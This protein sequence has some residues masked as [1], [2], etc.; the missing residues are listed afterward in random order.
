MNRIL[1]AIWNFVSSLVGGYPYVKFTCKINKNNWNKNNPVMSHL[2][3]E[4]TQKHFLLIFACQL[5]LRKGN[6]S[7]Y[8]FDI[9]LM[10]LVLLV[11]ENVSYCPWSNT[12]GFNTL[13]KEQVSIHL[14]RN[15]IFSILFT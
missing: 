15:V 6:V 2:V 1:A 13:F 7:N 4:V 3:F 12:N 5:S 14:L 8:P 9:K 10:V 11:Q